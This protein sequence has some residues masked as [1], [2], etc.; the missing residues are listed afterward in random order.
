MLGARRNITDL[1]D[2]LVQAH[3]DEL[4][5]QEIR[6]VRVSPL[7]TVQLAVS[8]TPGAPGGPADDLPF[9]AIVVCTDSN[10][11]LTP[12]EWMVE[13]RRAIDLPAVRCVFV[14]GS[15]CANFATGLD[16]ARGMVA[17]GVAEAVLLVT[18]DKILSGTRY[19]PISMTVFSDGAASCMVTATPEPGSFRLLGSA[20]EQWFDDDPGELVHART[21]LNAMRSAG[22]RAASGPVDTIGHMV[23]PNFGKA[24]RQLLAMAIPGQIRPH[25]GLVSTVGHCFAS[26]V[27]LNLRDLVQTGL[28]SD[29]ETV[30]A[31]AS[32]ATM[33]SAMVFEYTD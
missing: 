23:T 19:P 25:S 4:E 26:D 2:P 16:V 17:S 21:I 24:T 30:L 8:V 18:V 27:P 33:L 31:A 1:D 3:A 5:E 29:G 10:G 11:D 15:A 7:S 20:T 32:S 6:S 22:Y 12:T 28:L 14:S 9:Q 13:Y